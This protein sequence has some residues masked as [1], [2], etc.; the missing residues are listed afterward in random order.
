MRPV[1]LRTDGEHG[2][3]FACRERAEFPP[4]RAIAFATDAAKSFQPHLKFSLRTLPGRWGLRMNADSVTQRENVAVIVGP[5]GGQI[6][7][8]SNGRKL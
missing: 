6:T 4:F 5:R 8:L 2:T 7:P 3:H 1:Y